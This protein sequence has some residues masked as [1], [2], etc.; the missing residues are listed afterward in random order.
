MFSCLT[1]SELK[2]LCSF[3]RSTA[4]HLVF[5]FLCFAHL[6]FF[7]FA[8]SSGVVHL[9]GGVVSL[10]ACMMV[11]PRIG[12]FV[13]NAEGRL[14]PS[15][16]FDGSSIVLT[17][18]GTMI[19]WFG[20]Y[21]FNP[22]STL[23][24]SSERYLAAATASMN[25]TLAA[26]SALLSGLLLTRLFEGNYNFWDV[27]NCIL[28]GLVGIT[29]P[30]ATISPGWAIFVG[31]WS[32]L[33][34]QLCSKLILRLGID[35]VVGAVSVHGAPGIVGVMSAAL[36]SEQKYVDNAYPASIGRPLNFEVGHQFG[37]A[38]IQIL[39]TIA[40]VGV[41]AFIT[42]KILE[43]TIGIR[44]DR[45]DELVGLDFKYHSGYAYETQNARLQRA[46][47]QIERE[48]ILSE[49]ILREQ[50]DKE[51]RESQSGSG[52]MKK[53]LRSSNSTNNIHRNSG[54]QQG[55]GNVRNS[56]GPI[57]PLNAQHST[58]GSQ[59]HSQSGRTTHMDYPEQPSSPHRQSLHS[60][61]A[62]SPTSTN[63][64]SNPLSNP[65]EPYQLQKL[66]AL[67]A[68]RTPT[69]PKRSTD[70][71]NDNLRSIQEAQAKAGV[72]L[73]PRG[74]VDTGMEAPLVSQ[75]L[76]SGVGGATSSFSS[77]GTGSRLIGDADRKGSIRASRIGPIDEEARREQSRNGRRGTGNNGGAKNH[78]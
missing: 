24:M 8:F 33:T 21:G 10:V 12:R 78:I 1:I 72:Y 26:C 16:D 59:Q 50:Q 31:I 23:G 69:S 74:S 39:A 67:G 68:A 2:P 47:L 35:D 14:V 6:D 57:P 53:N 58:N 9:Q 17:S 77:P 54:I 27:L 52:M 64:N 70:E 49:K 61:V 56:G 43:K 18:L 62:S 51:S 7:L 25:T 13:K 65:N 76:P 3:S 20:W 11:G 22:G 19:L 37:V 34:Y 63:V 55:G 42:L 41:T 46:K 75:G 15:R 71:A 29:A 45:D 5:L 28:A 60:G 73:H 36:F 30:C 44:V 4:H 66:P 48:R 38:M 32:A 40:W